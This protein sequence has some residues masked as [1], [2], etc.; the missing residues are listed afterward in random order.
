[1]QPDEHLRPRPSRVPLLLLGAVLLLG[2][3]LWALAQG[4]AAP[5]ERAAEPDKAAQGKAE[6]LIR[7]LFKAK[8]D[9]ARD[10]P[11]AATALA[12]SLL[13]EARATTDDPALQ[14]VAYTHARQLAAR[15]GNVH[16]ALEALTELA[17]RYRVD[18]V[19]LKGA[20]LATAGDHVK[21]SEE[22]L[23]LIEAAFIFM[24]EMIAQDN[25]AP[26]AA[27]VA[28]AEKA[29]VHVKEGQIALAGRIKKRATE[30]EA[31]RKEFGRMAPFVD[32]LKKDKNDAEANLELGRYLVVIKGNFD[33]GLPLLTRGTDATLKALAAKDLAG[34]KDVKQ[35]VAL[36]DAWDRV[37]GEQK[38][39]PQRQLQRRAYYWYDKAL[40]QADGSD[41]AARGQAARG[42]GQA[43]RGGTGEADGRADQLGGHA[44]GADSGRQ[45]PDG[46]GQH[47]AG[48]PC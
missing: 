41:Q 6:T 1:M 14:F 16:L 32:R 10:D 12:L 17:K 8:Y 47:R 35:Q 20:T 5:Q 25:Y 36:A 11:A 19:D 31:A 26:A 48:L 39:L 13:D 46:G 18:A 40:P 30:V 29:T 42:A 43:A 34:P 45:V 37:A 24:D 7:N 44:V 9:K 15:A 2:P 33:R 21:S 28:A 23:T 27:V 3:G 38:Q 4:N 22:A